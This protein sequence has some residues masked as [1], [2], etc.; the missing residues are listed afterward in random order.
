MVP[1]VAVVGVGRMGYNHARVLKELEKKGLAVLAAVVD[2]DGVRARAVAGEFGTRAL[3][4]YRELVELGVDAVVV[5]VPTKL[6]YEVA[7]FFV[8]SGLDVLVEKPIADSVEK[9]EKLVR[10]AEEKGVVLMVGHVERFNPAVE[11]LVE[12]VE[13]GALGEL[14]T[15]SA[16]RIGPFN[17]RV[18]DVSVVI[19]LA[20]HDIDVMISLAQSKPVSVYARARKMHGESLAEDYAFITLHFESGVDGFIET[21]R[22]TPRKV[23]ALDVVGVKGVAHLDY[24]EQKLVILDDK[25]VREAVIE[26]AEPLARELQHFIECVKGGAEPRVTGRD[27]LNALVVAE[28]ALKSSREGR[29][30]ELSW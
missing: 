29:V 9:A 25:Y 26:R 24:I 18:S 7:S 14:I 1:R 13:A 16:R 2:V 5:A 12:E 4:D 8:E 11:R 22:L 19:D 28:A 3:T 10:A 15:M 30:V 27:G 21:N 6:H 20:F 17:P 23:R